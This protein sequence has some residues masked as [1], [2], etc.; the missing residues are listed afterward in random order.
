L[1][2]RFVWADNCITAFGFL[3]QNAA[4]IILTNNI[5]H[6]DSGSLVEFYHCVEA[7]ST[8][9]HQYPY[10]WYSNS[11]TKP[12]TMG[13]SRSYEMNRLNPVPATNTV[14]LQAGGEMNLI[15]ISVA[16]GEAFLAQR[17]AILLGQQ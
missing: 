6:G 15:P 10:K 14:F 9:Y 12:T 5:P 4:N 8:T 16:D 17:C 2:K 3:K 7:G 13:F 1:P 11:I